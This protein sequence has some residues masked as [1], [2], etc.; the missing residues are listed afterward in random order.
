V[1]F[2]S[3]NKL[4]KINELLNID[5][6]LL[7][8]GEMTREKLLEEFSNDI[9]SVLLGTSSFW[10]GVDV[11]GEALSCVIIDKLPFAVPNEPLVEARIEYI[12]KKEGNPFLEY[13]VPAAIISLKQGFG[14]L[15]RSTSDRGAMCLLDS[16]IQNRFY[17]KMFFR[18]SSSMPSY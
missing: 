12:R 1:L 17:G 14:R 9:S 16:R 8:Q 13:Q 4:N 15:I 7:K 11:R 6:R 2:T 5:F 10:E 18:K 3:K